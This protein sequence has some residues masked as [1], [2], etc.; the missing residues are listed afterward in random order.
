[1]ENL[2]KELNNSES[3]QKNWL[4]GN[5]QKELWETLVSSNE[6]LNNQIMGIDNEVIKEN[7]KYFLEKEI[8][9]PEKIQ[10]EIDTYNRIKAAFLDEWFRPILDKILSNEK[11][12]VLP[13][14]LDKQIQ[15]YEKLKK[16]EADDER[17]VITHYI[18][19][20][21]LPSLVYEE[22]EVYLDIKNYEYKSEDM[23]NYVLLLIRSWV[24][25]KSVDR[26]FD[27]IKDNTECW[28]ETQ[29]YIHQLLNTPFP[30]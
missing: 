20:W 1:M 18:E 3:V 8:F 6:D 23:K 15:F 21:L 5:I 2:E 16:V 29:R 25:P 13:S 7:I 17:G 9:T 24:R 10:G 4:P 26:I 30:A 11:M 22:Y 28:P 12:K 27:L 19:E 14:D